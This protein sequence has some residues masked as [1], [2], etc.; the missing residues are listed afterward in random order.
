[1]GFDPS[2][3]PFMAVTA[4][5][6][7]SGCAKH[8]NPKPLDT[9][10]RSLSFITFADVMVPYCSNVERRRSSSIVSSRFL[11]YRFTSWLFLRRSM[12]MESYFFLS[13]SLRS[14]SFSARPQYTSLSPPN[15]LEAL[16]L[17]TAALASSAPSKLT[18]PKP[19]LEPSSLRITLDDVTLPYFSNSAWNLSSATS[20]GMFLTYTLVNLRSP[21]TASRSPRGMKGP[22]KRRLSE[23]G[24]CMPLTLEM[25]SLASSA[26]SN[27]TNPKPRELPWSSIVTLHE[28]M[29]PNCEKVSW[30]VRVSTFF[31]RFL[32]KMLPAPDLR[33]EGSRCFHMM[34]H[35]LPLISV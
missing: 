33:I 28:R 17:S 8:T 4:R 32:M 27:C 11:M 20:S 25:A 9:S 15:A 18:K 13:L 31:S 7:S 35:A 1:M 5:V 29:L 19:R 16:M 30:R 34:R 2:I 22:T 24:R 10:A 21:V 14:D 23:G 6:A 12:R 3:C 26:V